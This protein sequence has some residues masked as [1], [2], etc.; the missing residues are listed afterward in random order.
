[1][2]AGWV[3]VH[4]TVRKVMGCIYFIL[5]YLFDFLSFGLFYWFRFVLFILVRFIVKLFCFYFILFYFIS[6][7]IIYFV[8]IILFLLFY[9]CYYF[10]I[11]F[12]LFRIFDIGIKMARQGVIAV[13][14]RGLHR[15]TGHVPRLVRKY[16]I[17][18]III[19]LRN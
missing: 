16:F 6:I 19:D 2:Y 4:H 14:E 3:R 10:I 11:L 12:Y 9:F 8:S 15:E 7:I 1:M 5:F 18:L 13:L 17:L